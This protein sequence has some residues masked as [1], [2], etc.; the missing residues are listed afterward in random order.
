MEVKAGE[1]KK[2]LKQRIEGFEAGMDVKLMPL[3]SCHRSDVATELLD[4]GALVVGSPT[5]NNN[6]FPTVADAIVYLKGL[7][8]KN[9]IGA[10]FGSYG[11]GGEAVKHI[12]EWL[13]G[14]GIELISDGLK[15]K[16][17]PDE[18]G[19]VR[20]RELGTLVAKELTNRCDSDG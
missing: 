12:N 16:Y 6:I 1:I 14:M 2:I 19:L 17:V 9:L 4:A 3:T 15:I 13:T 11:W 18:P 5:I 10:A 8:P 20:C 7:R